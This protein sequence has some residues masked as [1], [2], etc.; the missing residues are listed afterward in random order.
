MKGD[1]IYTDHGPNIRQ[2]RVK[3]WEH[4]ETTLKLHQS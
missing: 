4:L 3:W 2:S 1:F